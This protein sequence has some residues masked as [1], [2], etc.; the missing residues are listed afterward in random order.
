MRN[1]FYLFYRG[2]V[3]IRP[4][5]VI[6]ILLVLGFRKNALRM[7]LNFFCRIFLY[8]GFLSDEECDH[9]IM[10]VTKNLS[11]SCL[12]TFSWFWICIFAWFLL[13]WCRPGA[14]WRDHWWLI[15]TLGIVARATCVQ[16]PERSLKSTRYFVDSC[17]LNDA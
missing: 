5:I 9:I 8:K 17:L 12:C 11:L 4:G 7:H 14:R 15:V 16:A 2:N 6:L 1:K 13:I 10:L 3:N